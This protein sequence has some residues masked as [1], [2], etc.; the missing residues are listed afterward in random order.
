MSC[1]RWR[2]DFPSG[3]IAPIFI[4]KF[5][6][7]AL[8]LCVAPAPGW[9][10]PWGATDFAHFSYLSKSASVNLPC[11]AFL[12]HTS[13]PSN[14]SMNRD[15]WVYGLTPRDRNDHRNNFP[16][17]MTSS[18]PLVY[19]RR[20]SRALSNPCV[21]SA[22]CPSVS[23]DSRSNDPSPLVSRMNAYGGTGT[24]SVP[25][26]YANICA[27]ASGD[28]AAF[29]NLPRMSSMFA[30]CLVAFLLVVPV[31]ISGLSGRVASG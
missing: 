1:N 4:R 19:A 6:P 14:A 12:I 7:N 18:S 29:G 2:L 15:S 5:L 13:A 3:P 9:P 8:R 31:R 21:A 10:L 11:A 25:N 17:V 28:S 16:V 30:S 23:V 27:H 20:N 22:I 26:A 24:S